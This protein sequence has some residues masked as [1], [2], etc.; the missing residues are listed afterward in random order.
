MKMKND[1][2]KVDYLMCTFIYN[3]VYAPL[4]DVF[5]IPSRGCSS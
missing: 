3:L 1:Q 5:Y 2:L 4:I